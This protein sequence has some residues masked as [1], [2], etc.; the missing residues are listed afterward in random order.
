MSAWIVSRNHI[1]AL[2]QWAIRTGLVTAEQADATGRMLWAANLESVAYRY[3][4]DID[5]ERPGPIGF[6]DEHVLEYTYAPASA[7]AV[8]EW[9][10]GTFDPENPRDALRQVSCA[11]YQSCEHPGWHESDACDLL[12]RMERAL[13]PLAANAIRTERVAGTPYRELAWGV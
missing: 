13:K 2:V 9:T 5:G 11:F 7:E 8:Q 10:Y 3:P 6:R 1:N 4:N 12:N